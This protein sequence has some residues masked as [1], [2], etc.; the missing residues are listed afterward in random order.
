MKEKYTVYIHTYVCIENATI[1]VASYNV[2]TYVAQNNG[3]NI[4]LD[5]IQEI[6]DTLLTFE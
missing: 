3:G 4:N 6:F 2:R 1:Y 5:E